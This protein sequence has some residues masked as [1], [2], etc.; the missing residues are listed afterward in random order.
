MRSFC[1]SI[2]VILHLIAVP[3]LVPRANAQ[4]DT[5]FTTRPLFTWRDGV[6]AGAFIV[7]TISIRPLDKSA[8]LA[9]QYPARQKNQVLQRMSTVVRAIALPGST[10]IGP[11]MYAIGKLTHEPRLA[12]VGLHGTE[13]LLV[14]AGSG[15][16]SKTRLAARIH[17]STQ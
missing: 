10:I 6:L 12:E 1:K 13:A 16:F 11:S 17:S 8:A 2:A 9:L 5:I 7:A 4:A 14:G 3:S 15:V